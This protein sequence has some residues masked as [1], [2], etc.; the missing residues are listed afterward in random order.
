MTATG[1]AAEFFEE[2]RREYLSEAT[3]RLG[4][5]RKDLAALRAGERD[6]AGSLKVR[7]HRLAG[8]GGSYGFP[9]IS[10]ASRVTEHWIIANPTP[11][12]PGLVFLEESIGQIARAFDAAAIELGLPSTPASPAAFG[13][14]AVIVGGESPLVDRIEATLVDAQYQ[15]QRKTI[16]AEPATIPVSERPDVAVIVPPAKE[17]LAI[18]LPK[19]T[20]RGAHR[21]GV[22]VLVAPPERGDPLVEPVASADRVVAPDRIETDLLAAVRAV[23]WA[24]TAPRSVLIVDAG[25]HGADRTLMSALEGAGIKLT[26]V[27]GGLPAR[28]QLAREPPDL[29]LIEW[30][31]VDTSAATL[32]RWIRQQPAHRLT[33]IVTAAATIDDATRLLAIRSGADDVIART[34]GG[35]HVAQ[36][37]L[38]RIERAR[39]IRAAA[40][41]DD[42]TGL[43]NHDAM[44]EELE[45]AIR[46]ARRVSEPAALL[47]IDVD[48]FRRINE[49]HGPTVGDAVLVHVARL[50]AS[51]VRTSDPIARMGGEEF[52]VLVHRCQAADAG[53]VAE[54]IRSAVAATPL[55]IGGESV[56]VRISVGVACYPDRS[57]AGADV[58]RAADKALAKAKQTGRDR[59]VVAG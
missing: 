2:L 11:D 23:G 32:I 41:R 17:P 8:S 38:A 35:A 14:R 10:N 30:S 42:L 56:P 29:I 24:A 20:G 4:E 53:R 25:D 46:Y 13:W 21:P 3:A 40:H 19:W 34:A 16:A 48:H 22:V 26:Q 45:R 58:V 39:A 37:I 55:A 18:L 54:K 51:S 31:L 12:E 44:L 57:G 6:A 47:M 15:V 36:L 9:E 52:A 7:L 33:P 50:V 27:I 28:D 43:L 49:R 5:L 59:V 1:G